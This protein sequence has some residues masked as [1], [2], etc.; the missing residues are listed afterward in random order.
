MNSDSDSDCL[1]TDCKEGEDCIIV[2]DK[3]SPKRC[4]LELEDNLHL[5]SI[6][7]DGYCIANCFAVHFDENLD[8]V[9]DKLR[10]FA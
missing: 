7:G 2:K 9:L 6:T 8:K 10:N 1:I 5:K 3:P 4:K